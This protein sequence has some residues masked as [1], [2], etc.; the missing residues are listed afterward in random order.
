ML[1]AVMTAAALTLSACGGGGSGGSS[2][3]VPTSG[4]SSVGAPSSI[5][6]LTLVE[7]VSRNGYTP[8]VPGS[9]INIVQPGGT[10]RYSFISATTILG[11][12]VNVVPTTSWSYSLSGNV[13]TVKLVMPQG[14]TTDLLTFTSP[15]GGTFRSDG[16]LING[17]TFF[18]EGTFTVSNYVASSGSNTSSNT[19]STTGNSS[20]NSGSTSGNTS[21]G[22][23]QSPTSTTGRVVIWTSNSSSG[24]IDVTID[25]VSVG[26]LTKY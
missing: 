26:T 7:T 20:S 25:N 5:I 24:F 2:S 12:G 10:I 14:E 23:T 4:A 9:T 3:S 15:T 22:S 21:S 13:A 18:F 19:G 11:E 16:R 17:T 6:G 1:W 8:A